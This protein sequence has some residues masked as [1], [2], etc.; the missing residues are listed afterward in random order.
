MNHAAARTALNAYA[1]TSS[2]REGDETRDVQARD[3]IVDLLLMFEPETAAR[4]L[5]TAEQN[6]LE[7]EPTVTPVYIGV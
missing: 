7:E 3:L 2:P 1:A 6:L 4:I 5:I